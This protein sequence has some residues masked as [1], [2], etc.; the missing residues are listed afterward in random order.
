MKSNEQKLVDICFGL[1]MICSNK[2]YNDKF[3]KL[4][5]KRKADWVRAQL[6]G[7]GFLISGPV[8][9]SWGLYKGVSNE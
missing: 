8:G 3:K 2:E 9:L 6:T 5:N 4:T 1:V 7:N